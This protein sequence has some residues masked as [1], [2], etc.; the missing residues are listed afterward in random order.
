MTVK[1]HS[2]FLRGGGVN[3]K[4]AVVALPQP[5]LAFDGSP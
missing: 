5:T 4:G 1:I 3:V 2:R